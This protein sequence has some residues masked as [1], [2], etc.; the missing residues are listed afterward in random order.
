MYSVSYYSLG[1]KVNLYEC[2]SLINEFCKNGFVEKKF[3]EVCDCYI[4]NT[5][6][7]TSMSD[8][9][10][11]KIIRQAI[12]R[13]KDAIICVMGCFSQLNIDEV[14][15][16]EGVSIITGTSNRSKILSCVLEKLTTH[17]KTL[18]NLHNSYNEINDYEDLCITH[19]DNKTR[20]FVKIQDGCENFCSYCAI[21]LSR[22]KFRSRNKDSIIK[23]IN[24]LTK[25]NMKEIVLTGI[26]TGAYGKDLEPSYSFPKLLEDIILNVKGLGRIRISSI[27]ATEV[28]E[29]LLSVMKKYENHFCMHL[30]IPLQG[31]SDEILK[32][33][34]RKY[35][36]KYYLDKINYIRSI[37]PLI[38]ITC[39]V[40]VGFDGE[41]DELFNKSYEFIKS[42]N[43]GEMHVF[44]YS[45]RKNT[46]AYIIS[47]KCNF[48]NRVNDITKK[49]RVNE[50]LKLNEENA[51]K[52]RNLFLDKN[53]TVL[54]E[55]IEDGICFGH[56]SNYLEVEFKKVNCKENDL[57]N[58]KITNI[59]YP[60]CKGSEINVF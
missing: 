57:V 28:T 3:D 56:T 44:P 12:K 48:K 34:N 4:I 10:S 47:Q 14:S 1:C 42:I 59:S 15:K 46:K 22:G 53:V 6:T 52:Y 30:H 19:Y 39:D 45:P 2:V 17:D 5:C 50:L 7:V 41:T 24:L 11:R 31:G 9:K 49:F 13:N 58:V 37:F 27:E 54:V 40:M 55:K 8:Q 33:M 32:N 16:I 18:V 38:N 23:E 21:P 20:G 26:N 60:I 35:D 29:E 51:I 43:Y 25:N 36:T